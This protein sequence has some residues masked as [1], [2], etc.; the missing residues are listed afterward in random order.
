[1]ESLGLSRQAV[2]NELNS[3]RLRSFKLG[4][5]RM[6]PADALPAWLDAMQGRAA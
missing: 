3:G 2:Y 1:M 5:R 6:I 4:R